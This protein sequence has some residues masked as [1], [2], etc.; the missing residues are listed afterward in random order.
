MLNGIAGKARQRDELSGLTRAIIA[1]TILASSA[2]L[3]W[4]VPPMYAH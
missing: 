4:G 1:G 3:L 2:V